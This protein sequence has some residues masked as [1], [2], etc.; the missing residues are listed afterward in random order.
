MSVLIPLSIRT[1]LSGRS[2]TAEWSTILLLS[3]SENSESFGLTLLTKSRNKSRFSSLSV[4]HVIPIY[5]SAP[6]SETCS[7]SVEASLIRVSRQ[8]EQ[9]NL[10]S[11]RFFV[12]GSIFSHC[13]ASKSPLMKEFNLQPRP[14]RFRSVRKWP[15]FT[16]PLG[17][18]PYLCGFVHLSSHIFQIGMLRIVPLN[19]TGSTVPLSLKVHE[20]SWSTVYLAGNTMP[21]AVKLRHDSQYPLK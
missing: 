5:N 7:A 2:P 15:L 9:V 14:G 13:V 6:A 16:S 21:E 20:V 1:Y 10:R 12:K 4:S 8:T 11:N 3:A 17:T 19:P 18:L